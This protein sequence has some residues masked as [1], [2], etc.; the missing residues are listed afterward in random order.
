AL[1]AEVLV[2]G[3]HDAEAGVRENAIRMTEDLFL[4]DNRP[5]TERIIAELISLKND[6]SPKVRFQLLAS[7][8][9]VNSPAAAKARKDLLFDNIDDNWM[10]IAALS[11]IP[12]G[13][14]DLLKEVLQKYQSG[15]PQYA[16]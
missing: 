4:T 6:P 7:L 2:H 1:R 16:S 10:Q 14:D 9:F 15:N 5:E 3:L 11:A 8:G 13:E 12:F